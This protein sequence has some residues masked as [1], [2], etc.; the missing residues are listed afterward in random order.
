[1]HTS[2][3]RPTVSFTLS[4]Q[5]ITQRHLQSRRLFASVSEDGRCMYYA[6][7]EAAVDRRQR[8]QELTTGVQSAV[9]LEGFIERIVEEQF[10]R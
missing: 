7:A 1:V 4:F 5:F 3:R 6:I 2:A 9:F 8:T 10:L